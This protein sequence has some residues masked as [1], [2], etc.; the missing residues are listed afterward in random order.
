MR[1][2]APL[3]LQRQPPSGSPLAISHTL[4]DSLSG[5]FCKRL[6]WRVPSLFLLS[7]NLIY[8][9][10][11]NY[12]LCVLSCEKPISPSASGST[13][14]KVKWKSPLGQLKDTSSSCHQIQCIQLFPRAGP[15]LRLI[16]KTKDP[17]THPVIQ[18]EISVC[19]A[20]FLLPA[21]S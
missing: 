12:Q 3:V 5:Q 10:E 11:L 20:N 6:F 7:S 16:T 14:P 19:C 13:L 9:H 18:V 15:V 21:T 1:K 8:T 4:L 2:K 17:I